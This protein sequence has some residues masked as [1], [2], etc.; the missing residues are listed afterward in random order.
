VLRADVP[1]AQKARVLSEWLGVSGITVE[2]ENANDTQ[3]APGVYERMKAAM[4]N[5]ADY[6]SQ[7]LDLT[8]SRV[9]FTPEQRAEIRDRWLAVGGSL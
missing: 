2:R 7:M 1:D 8:A 9:F 4:P 5:Q 6:V 3:S